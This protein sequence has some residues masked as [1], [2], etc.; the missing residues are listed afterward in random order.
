VITGQVLGTNAEMNKDLLVIYTV[1]P[2]SV[3]MHYG[4]LALTCDLH[5]AV[6]Y[7]CTTDF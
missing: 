4:F 7:K 3:Q 5:S 6:L 2:G 1:R